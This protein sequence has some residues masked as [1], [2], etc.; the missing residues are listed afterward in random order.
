MCLWVYVSFNGAAVHSLVL[1]S[2]RFKI[3]R[4]Y[5]SKEPFLTSEQALQRRVPTLSRV[6]YLPI[7]PL[8]FVASWQRPSFLRKEWRTEPRAEIT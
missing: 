3:L 6:E 5:L 8:A 2:M 4:A 7:F 1:K